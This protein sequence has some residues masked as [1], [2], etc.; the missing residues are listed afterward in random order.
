MAQ[1]ATTADAAD[2]AE[3][4][5]RVVEKLLSLTMDKICGNSGVRGLAEFERGVRDQYKWM[6]DELER[7]RAEERHWRADSPQG[8]RCAAA[9]A[10]QER[11][12]AVVEGTILPMIAERKEAEGQ[13]WNASAKLVASL[14][15]H[16]ATELR[17][18]RLSDVLA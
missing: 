13:K 2:T 15:A 9:V 1:N 14:R 18:W 3:R 16:L 10:R 12:N 6:A 11:A 5:R 17:D 4:Q 8:E 7:L